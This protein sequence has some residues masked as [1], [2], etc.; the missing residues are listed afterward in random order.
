M[1][2]VFADLRDDVLPHQAQDDPT[3]PVIAVAVPF[4]EHAASNASVVLGTDLSHVGVRQLHARW[5]GDGA[6]LSGESAFPFRILAVLCVGAEP[7]MRWV[8]ADSIVACVADQHPFRD[9][10]AR[11]SERNPVR[12]ARTAL[13]GHGSVSVRPDLASPLDAPVGHGLGLLPESF[14][15]WL[16]LGSAFHASTLPVQFC[17]S[18]PLTQFVS[19]Q[20]SAGFF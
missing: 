10:T 19:R 20:N 4:G 17:L 3:H 12:R 8:Y 14:G 1:T 18:I 16:G 13:C 9:R 2:G 11:Q 5:S 6:R 15:E 7:E